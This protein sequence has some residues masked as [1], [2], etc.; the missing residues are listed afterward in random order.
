MATINTSAWRDRGVVVDMIY[1][2]SK[3]SIH[4]SISIE[5]VFKDKVFDS[6]SANIM[7]H[8]AMS[9]MLFTE[10]SAP[11]GLLPTIRFASM[12]GWYMMRVI[13][14]GNKLRGAMLA[15]QNS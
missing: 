6:A 9:D 7:C 15:V 10:Y 4:V 11:G 1:Y 5:I 8:E 13:D 14:D 3:P 12:D 2:K